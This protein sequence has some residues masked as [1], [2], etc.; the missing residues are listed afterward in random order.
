MSRRSGLSRPVRGAGVFAFAACLLTIGHAARAA[1]Q[2]R[3]WRG[4][5]ADPGKRRAL[6]ARTRRADRVSLRALT[7]G[8]YFE[9]RRLKDG[10]IYDCLW[11]AG[12]ARCAPG[13]PDLPV[14]SRW[15]AIPNGVEARLAVRAGARVALGRFDIGPVQ[16]L[17]PESGRT[18]PFVRDAATFTTDAPYPGVFA[19]ID[20][21]VNAR[22]HRLALVVCC[23]YQYNPVTRELDVYPELEADLRFVGQPRACPK[24]LRS[25]AADRI[26]MRTDPSADGLGSE[27]GPA[28]AGEQTPGGEWGESGAPFG[29]TTNEAEFLIICA[30]AFEPAAETLAAWRMRRGVKTLV[31]T[32]AETGTSTNAIRAYIRN[33]YTNWAVPPSYCLLIGDVARI[34]TF[35]DPFATDLYYSDMDEPTD[36]TA[37]ITLGRWPVATSTQA[38]HCA[39]RVIEYE[40]VRLP[41]RFYT[42]STHAGAFQDGELDDE[43]PPDHYANRRFAK[44]SED[45]YWGMLS[46][47]IAPRRVY[48]TYDGY[49]HAHGSI[50][51]SNWTATA[52][53]VFENDGPGGLPIPSYL[54]KPTFPW[55]GDG[56]EIRAAINAGTF[57]VTHRDH[58]GYD[59]WTAPSFNKVDVNTLSN[60]A[61]RPVV[62]SVNCLAGKFNAAADCLCESFLLHPT[63]GAIGCIGSTEESF[64]GINDRLTLGWMDTIWPNF[65]N[66][67][68][69]AHTSGPALYR[70]GDVFNS[71]KLYMMEH[72]PGDPDMETAVKE[73]HWLGDPML[74]IWTG[75]PGDLVVSNPTA[76]ALSTTSLVVQVD[77]DGATVAC[78]FDATIVG[79]AVSTA[80]TANVAISADALSHV[81][82]L[83]VTVTKH[84]YL[85]VCRTTLVSRIGMDHFV[86]ATGSD[87]A[88]YTNWATAAHIVQDAIDA[89]VAGDF[90]WV[91][92]GV[93]ETGGRTGGTGTLTNRVMIDKAIRV[94]SVN[95]RAVTKLRG[96]G[97]YGRSATRCAYLSDGTLEGFTLYNGYTRAGDLDW[98]PDRSGGGALLNEGG[99]IS[100]CLIRLCNAIQFGGGLAFKGG[101]TVLDST[102]VSNLNMGTQL[103]GGGA[104]LYQGGAISNSLILQNESW[105]HG[106]GVSFRFGGGVLAD[107][108]VADN[109]SHSY[110]GGIDCYQGGLVDRCVVVSNSAGSGG[111]GALL[112]DGGTIQNSLVITNTTGGFGGGLYCYY[113]GTIR[114][115]TVCH[116]LA[117]GGAAYGGG[118]RCHEGGSLYNT[119]IYHN[120]AAT[121][122]NVTNS[123]SGIT[124]RYCSTPEIADLP[125][126]TGC[127]TAEPDFVDP[128]AHDYRQA[129]GSPCADIGENAETGGTLDLARYPRVLLGAV[130]LGAYESIYGALD[131]FLSITQYPALVDYDV[132]SCV[133]RGTNNVHVVGTMSVTNQTTGSNLTFGAALAWTTPSLSVAYG[134]NTFVVRGSN[135][136]GA[137]VSDTIL[138]RRETFDEV[139]PFLAITNETPGYIDYS[140]TTALVRGTNNAHISG[141]MGWIL[142]S[143]PTATNW[144]GRAGTSWQ[145][146]VTGLTP[147]SN[148]VTVVGTNAYGHGAS[149]QTVIW[150]LP[151]TNYVWFGGSHAFPYASW[152]DAATNIQAAVDAVRNGGLVWVTNGNYAVG[153]VCVALTNATLTNRVV[154]SR[155][156]TV[157][158]VN[159]RDATFIAGQPDPATG[160]NGPGAVRGVYITGGGTLCGFTVTNGY[161][162]DMAGSSH[163]RCGAGVYANTGSVSECR[164]A[165][166][167]A[168]SSGGGVN[169]LEGTLRDS[170]L[171]DNRGWCGAGVYSRDAEITDCTI[172]ANTSHAGSSGG[173]V[174][175]YGTIMLRCTIAGN[176]AANNAGGVWLRETSLIADCVISN[177]TCAADGGG[178]YLRD[179]AALG[180][181]CRIL[182]NHAANEGGGLYMLNGAELR[183]SLLRGNRADAR[184]GGAA[185]TSGSGPLE[186]CTI[187]FNTSGEEGGGVYSYVWDT[188]RNCIVYD[189]TRTGS[190]A[191]ANWA[192]STSNCMFTASCT[193]PTNGLGSAAHCFEAEPLFINTNAADFRLHPDSPC[194]NAG[195]NL[196]WTAGSFDL[197]GT[198][199]VIAGR[200]DIGAYEALT[201]T[202]WPFVDITNGNLQVDYPIDA[203]A[204][205]G[206]NNSF[207]VGS[208]RW[209]NTLNG[210]AGTQ[211]ATATWTIP[212]VPLG[213]GS[214][215]ISV[216]VTNATGAACADCVGITRLAEGEGAPL[217]TITSA[218]GPVPLFTENVAVTGTANAHV[219]GSL[220]WTNAASG[221]TGTEPAATNWSIGAVPLGLGSNLVSVTGTNALGAET[222]DSVWFFRPA[223][224]TNYVS[225]DG[226]H[227]APYVSWADA[228]TNIQAAIDSAP[229]AGVVLVTNGLYELGGA[230]MNGYTLTNRVVVTNGLTVR[231]VNGPAVTTIVGAGPTG[232]NAVRGAAVLG[233]AALCGFT[234]SNG[235]T[236]GGTGELTYERSGGGALVDGGMLSNCLI[237]NNHASAQGAGLCLI[238]SGTV[239]ECVID[240]N[241]AGFAGGGAC[242]MAGRMARCTVRNNAVS[243]AFCS[244]GGVYL[245]WGGGIENCVVYGN[246]ADGSAG[247]VYAE[248]CDPIVNCT[249]CGN[250]A[251]NPFGQ[252]GGLIFNM[253][254]ITNTIIYHNVSATDSNWFTFGIGDTLASCC[255]APTNF[256]AQ[257]L[258]C[259]TDD[260]QLVDLGAGDLR[261]SLGSP[262]ID[263][264]AAAAPDQDRDGVPRP[265]DGDTN[266]VALPDMGAYE[267]GH[268]A[269]DTDG[270]GLSDGHEIVAG[271]DPLSTSSVFEILAF[272]GVAPD[273]TVTMRWSSVAG[274]TYAIGRTNDLTAGFGAPIKTNIVATPP[275][276]EDTDTP[277]SADGPW[278]YRIEVNL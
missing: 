24:R 65:L 278:F 12:A 241:T 270:D 258:D 10:R 90:V 154:I 236:A 235:W 104:L 117:G 260:P 75:I 252:A 175:G 192:A 113:G 102:V 257:F 143:M 48:T 188:L 198:N 156:I 94:R 124:Y 249:I 167:N 171:E 158:S 27:S 118:V 250:S 121:Q 187:S 244:G 17:D 261:L 169:L 212:A 79:T 114:N 243:G 62:F 95:G 161:T 144:F 220:R 8:A 57:L 145:A 74:E 176:N 210:A 147:G 22:A 199:R 67:I 155:P 232:S 183:N 247:G 45:L 224:L 80:G 108:R 56:A 160:T 228:A 166:C 255:T 35:L 51:P 73:F 31:A 226:D 274:R 134:T 264:G 150:R 172:W 162:H 139:Q 18:R 98:F 209:T 269:W 229:I 25:P 165:W 190:V 191:G 20:R 112:T 107:S 222:T 9:R 32:T 33:A 256:W 277:P 116:N 251:T 179:S 21:I 157:R 4:T 231:S 123:G 119:I 266:G 115:A 14:L 206:S 237:C 53:Y 61:A 88:P 215:V 137:T 267:F 268:P 238:S 205:G 230:L 7:R 91:T 103:G 110:G 46:N 253:V 173:G 170:I 245:S 129:P 221:S 185:M 100:N 96:K 64:S 38:M 153:G 125:D 42:N 39:E 223:F 138:V 265:L 2:W 54:L 152:S 3:E 182:D 213:V 254:T 218:G 248:G 132:A 5:G 59:N 151:T 68:G 49:S 72:Y 207:T 106:G 208:M 204:L 242:L 47:G 77:R 163:D 36:Y 86:A 41:D 122:P 99:Q 1:P 29:G 93:Y 246:T 89:A 227:V 201:G 44:T 63:G 111:G 148:H 13:Q 78:V 66:D 109:Y 142:A 70:M 273:G 105:G 131:P 174:Y 69:I 6:I 15:V 149:D 26:L 214:N 84:D 196:D 184:G 200:V 164:I 181:R 82:D 263:T 203:L 239:A 37:D 240:G 141:N 11:A 43:D 146:T 189:N 130:D 97:T 178:L 101:G 180:D 135:Y 81:G 262:C 19:R 216:I 193:T 197:A 168:R 233:G 83:W 34:P 259:T 55:D 58:A 128:P 186:N 52:R 76:I 87:T 159:G 40:S 219:I 60:G 92:N 140:E 202:G 225:L 133:L 276:N 136:V 30:P 16:Q 120:F 272:A 23:P 275:E 85:P 194:I 211:P 177:N 50:T 71:G 271:T 28:I 234:L 126:G 195:T 217:L 127:T